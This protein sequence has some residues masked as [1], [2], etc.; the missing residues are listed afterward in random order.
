MPHSGGMQPSVDMNPMMQP[1][2]GFP[3]DNAPMNDMPMGNAPDMGQMPM[4]DA[5]A[6]PYEADFDAG[7]EAN[8][9]ED[10]KKFIQQLTGKLSQSLRKYNEN[11]PQPDGDLNKYVAG[12]VVKQCVEGLPQE[13]KQEILDKVNSDEETPS[14]NGE[15]PMD[16]TQGM[17]A[18]EG[19]EMPPADNQQMPMNETESRSQRI[20]NRYNEL[21]G[22]ESRNGNE[23]VPN[24]N[25]YHKKPFTAKI[26]KQ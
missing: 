21:T 6:N 23:T 11:L 1:D 16:D 15:M 26:F 3:M 25:K 12:M 19:N 2:G 10:P 13:D 7:V 9:E 14:D 17:P 18:P 24:I 5:E 8:E 4:G 20:S 22:E